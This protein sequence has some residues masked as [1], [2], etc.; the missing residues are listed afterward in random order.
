[1]SKIGERTPIAA[2]LA[3]TA[4]SAATCATAGY[5]SPSVTC[6]ALLAVLL[7]IGILGIVKA[8][9]PLFE[10]C[11]ALVIALAATALVL[12]WSP[13][14]RLV[15]ALPG[16][17]VG[18]FWGAWVAN[19]LDVPHRQGETAGAQLSE[20]FPNRVCDQQ[21][22]LAESPGGDQPAADE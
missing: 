22:P 8:E 7:P 6:L 21:R 9:L 14:A 2:A 1:V 4:A 13:V 12:P 17:I 15:L 3:A 10:Y 20:G 18:Y 11:L 5:F 16:A 19:I